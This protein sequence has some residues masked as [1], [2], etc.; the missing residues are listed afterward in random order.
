MI[1]EEPIV[2]I[3][4]VHASLLKLNDLETT[5]LYTPQ[6]RILS[7]TD[8]ALIRS[9]SPDDNGTDSTISLA[10]DATISRCRDS[11][12]SNG[13]STSQS[14]RSFLSLDNPHAYVSLTLTFTAADETKMTSFLKLI[15]TDNISPVLYD[16]IETRKNSARLSLEVVLEMNEFNI[17]N[18]RYNF[19]PSL[20]ISHYPHVVQ[21]NKKIF[22]L[23]LAYLYY[24]QLIFV[25][26][27]VLSVVITISV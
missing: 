13:I 12:I 15:S 5:P 8:T 7:Q 19:E 6:N 16:D 10:K 27:E 26:F 18:N 20:S 17:S 11:I 4:N 1:I 3:L 22:N 2:Q 25:W 21:P 23:L 9:A 24:I 14:T